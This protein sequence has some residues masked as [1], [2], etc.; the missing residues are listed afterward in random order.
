MQKA[1]KTDYY[2]EQT[3]SE[4]RR[5][6]GDEAVW[7]LSSAK[8]D[9]GVHQ[10]RDDNSETFWQSDGPIPHIVNIQFMKKTRVTE[11]GFLLEF[12]TDESYTPQTISVRGGMYMQNLREIVRIELANPNGWVIIPLRTR[13]DDKEEQPFVYTM[14]IQLAVL[15]M[16]HQ[17]K[18]T[19]V[20]QVK[21]FG[22]KEAPERHSLDFS[23]DLGSLNTFLR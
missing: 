2:I 10:L 13:I 6:I 21:V 12:R 7:S 11:I 20:R 19:H 22:V 14:N 18:D 3:L 17:G 15:Q 1:A 9:S 23:S 4:T 5:E 16:F 8:Q